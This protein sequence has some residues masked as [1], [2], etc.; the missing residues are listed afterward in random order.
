MSDSPL[1][2]GIGADLA[3]APATANDDQE[4]SRLGY[5]QKLHRTMG[6]FTSFALAFSMVSINT[7]IVSLFADPF[8]RVG[9]IG[10]LL[11]ALV[12][13]LVGAI[14]AVYAHLAGRMPITGY[15][16]QWSSRLA[17]RHFGWFTGWVALISFIAG[18]A[19]TSAAIGSVFAPEIWVE[20]TQFQVQALSIAATLVVCMLNIFGIRITTR[21]NDIG[22]VIELVGTL[23]LAVLLI[24]GLL[25]FFG[26]TQGPGV[27]IAMQPTSGKPI[28]LETLALATLLPV[29]VLL[30]WEGAADL[31]EETKDP[32]RTAPRAMFQAVL[33]SSV[34]GLLVFALLGMSIPGDIGAFLADP[35]NPVLHLVRVQLGHLAGSLMTAVAFVSIFA[36]LIAN[37]AVATRMVYALSR[38]HM[39]P[40]SR[41]L[42][43]VHPR[44]GTP[45]AA[46][47]LVTAIAVVLNFAS[48]GFVTAIY[49]MVGLTYYLTY[50]L[51]LVAAI[52]AWRAGRIPAAPQG[53]FNLGRWLVPLALIGGLWTL[54]VIATLSIPDENR[55]AALTTIVALVIGFVWWAV[56]LRGR[57]NSG[58]AGAPNS[59]GAQ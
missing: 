7:G 57:L 12:I 52:I 59:A 15:A 24:A 51:T 35:E 32:R 47:L 22:A 48:G 28:S 33:V 34:L 56:S 8:T 40:G 2:I 13:P 30:G 16:Y 21:I 46:I 19:A 4:L 27:L 43:A 9:G 6:P 3:P 14:V 49:S 42:E 20:P 31:A 18:T 11:W 17:G 50:F 45:D 58:V 54:A 38:D 10:I 5:Q 55:A 23:A 36:C 1:P 29:S 53:V 25:F 26:Q 37:M 39:L 44:R 41:V